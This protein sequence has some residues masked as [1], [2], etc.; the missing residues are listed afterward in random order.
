M[1]RYLSMLVATAAFAVTPFIATAHPVITDDGVLR[2]P[3]ADREAPAIFCRPLYVC[4]IVLQPGETVINVAIGDSSRWMISP[5][6]SGS[7]AGVTPHILIKPT[8][9]GLSTN[10]IVTTNKRAYY[11]DLHSASVPPMERV[12]FT[13]PVQLD[14]SNEK[15]DPNGMAMESARPLDYKYSD[16]GAREL[17]P[18][19]IYND[20][21]H[22]YLTLDPHIEQLPV[23]FASGP[24]GDQLINYRVKDGSEYII[25]GVPDRIAL[26]V[27]SG[28]HELRAEIARQH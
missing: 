15:A 6:S 20:G 4:D 28:K 26:V 21:M 9:F 11:L 23:L 17:Y 12:G 16:S 27:G 3:F 18:A 10:L 1:K 19:T 22:T 8:E 25:D 2:F 13:Y 14:A 7:N 5:G 24:D